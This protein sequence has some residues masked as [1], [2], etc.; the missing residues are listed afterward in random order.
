MKRRVLVAMSG[1]VDSSVAALRLQ[2]QGHEVVGL[3]MRTGVH[4]DDDRPSRK[5]GCCSSLDARDARRVADHLGIP[6]HALDF[7]AEFAG[8]MDYFA[9][10]YLA[11]RTPNPCVEC[12]NRLKFGK[13]WY[14]AQVLEADHVATGHHAR[15]LQG[16]LHRAADPA[17][18][19]SYVLFGLPR[20]TLHRVLFPVGD[21]T[22]AQVRDLARQ[23][24]LPVH[25]KPDSQE[26]C[27]VPGGDHA[28]FVRQRRP[29]AGVAGD[30]VTPTGQVVGRHEGIAAFTVG[31]RKGLGV[32]AGA[33]RYVLELVP[34][35]ATVVVGTRAEG[36]ARGLVAERCNWFIPPPCA[37]L[38]VEAK[39]AYKA[40]PVG[41]QVVA[42]ADNTTTVTF[43]E[44]QFGVAPGQAAVF[45]HGSR[46]LGG[47]WI[48]RGLPL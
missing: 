32:A 35:T 14:L 31:Q 20:E 2:R 42:G 36:L 10:E 28:E 23:A 4:A 11:G 17:K 12:N 18:D 16:E 7:S 43:D 27:F 9:D 1:G 47:G 6:F 15:I 39:I 13:L 29:H 40:D 3:F 37:P 19:Q 33:R 45:Y 24:G 25:D 44:P 48:T 34:A 5:Q 26:I 8:V 38:R 41:A 21:L 46:V 30:I 22:K